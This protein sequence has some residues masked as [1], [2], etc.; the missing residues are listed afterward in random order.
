MAEALGC[1]YTVPPALCSEHLHCW[2]II[3]H[4]RLARKCYKKPTRGAIFL[5][6]LPSEAFGQVSSRAGSELHPGPGDQH[7][8]GLGKREF[9]TPNMSIFEDSNP[10]LN[11]QLTAVREQGAGRGGWTQGY[12]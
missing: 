5:P 3:L 6:L 8:A 1:I 2:H 12:G 7:H 11:P 9:P 10:T 4:G